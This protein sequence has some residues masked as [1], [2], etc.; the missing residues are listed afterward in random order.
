M[1]IFIL[2]I[3]SLLVFAGITLLVTGLLQPY[4]FFSSFIGLPAG[5]VSV[6]MVFLIGYYKFVK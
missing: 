4:I 6:L 2:I 5:F 1:K 3:I